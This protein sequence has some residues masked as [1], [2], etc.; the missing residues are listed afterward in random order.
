[1]LWHVSRRLVWASF[2]DSGRL[3]SAFRVAE[4]RTL[5]NADDKE[6]KLADGATIGIPHPL[7]LGESLKR[8]SDLFADYEILQ[9]FAQLGRDVYK[10]SDEEREATVLARFEG[11]KVETVKVLGLERFGWERGQAQ[12]AG[13]Q[14]WMFRRVPHERAVVLGLEPGIIAGAATEWKEQTLREIWLNNEPTGDWSGGPDKK[15]KFGAL[16]EVTASEIV[17]DLRSLVAR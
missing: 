3:S 14:G 11:V 10:L 6:L 8:W 16:D 13:I 5:A 17:R 15:L 12:D 2:E 1:L 9:P 7:H 4:D